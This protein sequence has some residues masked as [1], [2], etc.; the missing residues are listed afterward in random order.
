M[1]NQNVNEEKKIDEITVSVSN[2]MTKTVFQDKIDTA[3]DE[4]GIYLVYSYTKDRQKLIL[5][6]IGKSIDLPERVTERHEHYK[7]WLA[8]AD[9][10]EENLSFSI[11]S[12]P[13]YTHILH[14]EAALIFA[15]QPLINIQNKKTYDWDDLKVVFSG[16]K[17]CDRDCIVARRTGT[18]KR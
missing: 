16:R 9:G 15:L 11:I 6:Y 4:R 8:A 10:K 13:K 2:H 1:A 7:D 17:V 3:F 18:P 12:L 5:Q 14:C